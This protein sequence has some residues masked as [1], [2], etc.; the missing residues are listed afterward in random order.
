MLR[1]ETKNERKILIE[2]IMGRV[3]LRELEINGSVKTD[4]KEIR[5]EDVNWIQLSEAKVQCQAYFYTIMN[6]WASYNMKNLFPY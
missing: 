2:K 5:C 1:G 6:F 3:D 4:F